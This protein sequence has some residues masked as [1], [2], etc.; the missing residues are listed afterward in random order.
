MSDIKETDP[1][2]KYVLH[3]A[4]SGDT[5]FYEKEIDALLEANMGNLFII[6]LRASREDN[7]RYPFVMNVVYSKYDWDRL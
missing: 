1:R 2:V 6:K 5:F 4:G 3:E 7:S